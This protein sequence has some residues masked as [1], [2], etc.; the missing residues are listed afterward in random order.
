MQIGDTVYL[1]TSQSLPGTIHPGRVV[2]IHP[3]R[4]FYVAEFSFERMPGVVRTYRES[5]FFPER[6]GAPD[7]TATAMTEAERK[8]RDRLAHRKKKRK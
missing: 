8:Q 7:Y 4:R 6:A 1:H 2:Y 5:F 3:K